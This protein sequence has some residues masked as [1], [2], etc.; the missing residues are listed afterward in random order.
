MEWKFMIVFF[1]AGISLPRSEAFLSLLPKIYQ[2]PFSHY[3]PR[4]ILLQR[5]VMDPSTLIDVVS[6][7]VEPIPFTPTTHP[8]FKDMVIGMVLAFASDILA[9][10]TSKLNETTSVLSTT[11]HQTDTGFMTAPSVMLFNNSDSNDNTF[12]LFS[13]DSF[14]TTL[15]PQP[16]SSLSP[17]V[18]SLFSKLLQSMKSVKLDYLR[19][20]RFAVFG[21]FDG[22]VGHSWFHTLESY[23]TEYRIV[24][25][26]ARIL[27]DAVI[28]T[29]IW[30]LWFL[31]AMNCLEKRS[32]FTRVR[33][34][35]DEWLSLVKL[36]TS[37]YLP[38]SVVL[39]SF[40]PIERRVFA[41]A[42]GTMI[43]TVFLSIWNATRRR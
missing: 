4:Q 7:T 21:F 11:G 16:P 43:C 14:S 2:Q 29:P 9:Q 27:A 38:I 13:P 34:W 10:L 15:P 33:I 22:A 37:V 40:I 35:L 24:D 28:Y 23:I 41:S 42:L 1:L 8:M 39:Y 32:P 30:C 6:L 31:T 18:R 17:S 26:I 20:S 12:S 25:I 3:Y 19:T 36:S 5:N